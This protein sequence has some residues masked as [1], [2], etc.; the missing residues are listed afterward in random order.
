MRSILFTVIA[1]VAVLLLADAHAVAATDQEL[2]PEVVIVPSDD[3]RIEEFRKAGQLFM[4]KVTPRKGKPYFLVDADGDGDFD[5]RVT[6]FSPK[7]LIPAW[8][9]FTW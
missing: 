5:R 3:G 9:I 1:F 2:R 4:I 8:E 7:M 6:E